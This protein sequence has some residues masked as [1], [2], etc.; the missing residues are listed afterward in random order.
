MSP[1]P[2]G[3]RKEECVKVECALETI[4]TRAAVQEP[5]LYPPSFC[6]ESIG[7]LDVQLL[8]AR[9][10]EEQIIVD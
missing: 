2:Q 8:T 6:P 9:S 7:G 3:R 5:P 10:R 1:V 4:W